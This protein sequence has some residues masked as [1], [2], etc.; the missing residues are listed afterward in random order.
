LSGS[1][2]AF[3]EGYGVPRESRRVKGSARRAETFF[4]WVKA[5]FIATREIVFEFVF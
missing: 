3:A 1:R 4:K 5:K 2:A